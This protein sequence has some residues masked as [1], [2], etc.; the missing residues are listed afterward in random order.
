MKEKIR[1]I[2]LI[3]LVITIIILLI[4]A[5]ITIVSLTNSGLFEKARQAESKYKESQNQENAILEEYE[6]L[7]NNYGEN[8]KIHAEQVSFTPEDSNWK[9]ENV[10]EALDYLY[11]QLGGKN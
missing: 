7:I 1:G 2:T 5:G 9:V 10:K 8:F 3:A 11:N 4:L 6:N